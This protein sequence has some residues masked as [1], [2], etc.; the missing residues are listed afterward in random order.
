MTGTFNQSFFSAGGGSVLDRV[1]RFAVRI[2][3]ALFLLVAVGAALVATTFIG[4]MLAAGAVILTVVQ[5][6]MRKRSSVS[7]DAGEGEVSETLEAHRTADGW[8]TEVPRRR[9]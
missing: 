2:G 9:R 3:L 8:V 1:K 7:A 6:F 4:L 5:G